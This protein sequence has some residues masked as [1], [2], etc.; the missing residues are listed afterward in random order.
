MVLY[1]RVRALYFILSYSIC[2]KWLSSLCLKTSSDRTFT[3]SFYIWE[4]HPL[5]ACYNTPS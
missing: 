2:E 1:F 3:D 4:G 5:D